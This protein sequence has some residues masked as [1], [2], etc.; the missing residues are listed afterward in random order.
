M[1]NN[2]FSNP[3]F[4]TKY[5]NN[6]EPNINDEHK[7]YYQPPEQNNSIYSYDKYSI[8]DVL[9]QNKGKLAKIY[10]TFPNNT[11]LNNKVFTGIIETS[12]DDYITI[13]DPS[14][15]KWYLLKIS[16]IDFAEFD[17]SINIK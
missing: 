14:N 3:T 7:Y 11:E 13:S 2:Y 5:Q 17:E 16:S 6:N 12:G 10:A 8:N 15:G 9:K 4:P 1:N